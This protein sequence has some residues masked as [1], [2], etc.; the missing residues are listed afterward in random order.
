MTSFTF[1]QTKNCCL[2]THTQ[3][4]RKEIVVVYPEYLF[5]VPYTSWDIGNDFSRIV[6]VGL[7]QEYYISRRKYVVGCGD[8]QVEIKKKVYTIWDV[9]RILKKWCYITKLAKHTSSQ[10]TYINSRP[11]PIFVGCF[12]CL[13][14]SGVLNIKGRWFDI[15]F[16]LC[17]TVELKLVYHLWIMFHNMTKIS[18]LNCRLIF[19]NGFWLCFFVQCVL[20]RL[21]IFSCTSHRCSIHIYEN[22]RFAFVGGGTFIDR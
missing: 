22:G 21:H 4:R 14:R 18:P 9:Y 6:A 3:K 7:H 2:D 16:F 11:V 20:F 19:I 15:T 12:C 1:T 17:D 8:R 5:T 13:Y 10:S